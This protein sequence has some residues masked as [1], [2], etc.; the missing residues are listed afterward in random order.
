[1]VAEDGEAKDGVAEDVEAKDGEAEYGEMIT[2]V[3]LCFDFFVSLST[4]FIGVLLT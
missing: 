1:M 3:S 2:Y 4:K